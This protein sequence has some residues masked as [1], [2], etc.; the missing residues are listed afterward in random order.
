MKIGVLSDTHIPSS[1]ASLPEEVLKAFEGVDMILHAGDI[2]TLSVVDELCAVAETH[3][4]CGNM[5]HPATR[6]ALEAK[7]VIRAGDKKIGLI[8]GGGPPWGLARRV[9]REFDDVDAVVFG[10]SHRAA[11][12]VR[13]GTLLFN[14]GSPTDVV[15]APF[16]SYGILTVHDEIDG[17]IVRF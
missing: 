15:F 11:K 13:R 2:L 14:P 7:K 5:D 1:A 4:V 17:R 12:I 3:A 6:S 16:R 10:H 9:A 8:H